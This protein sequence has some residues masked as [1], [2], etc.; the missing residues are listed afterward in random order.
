MIPKRSSTTLRP[1]LRVQCNVKGRVFEAT[2]IERDEQVRGGWRVEPDS[3]NVTYY[4]VR[5]RDIKMVERRGP[6]QV[7]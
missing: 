7:A 6:G 2:L 4:H 5:G 3:S 1:G